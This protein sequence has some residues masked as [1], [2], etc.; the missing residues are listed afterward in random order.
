MTK[1]SENTNTVSGPLIIPRG[2]RIKHV[3]QYIGATNWRVEEMLRNGELR[4]F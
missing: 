2:L 4:S 1:E 3:A